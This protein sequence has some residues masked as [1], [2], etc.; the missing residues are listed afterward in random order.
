M[1]R[2]IIALLFIGLF[3]NVFCQNTFLIQPSLLDKSIYNYALKREIILIKHI[4]Y[5]KIIYEFEDDYSLDVFE[6]DRK[7]NNI[8]TM[9][10]GGTDTSFIYTDY[11]DTLV[12][13]EY[14]Y[15]FTYKDTI[16]ISQNTY[17]EKGQLE[18][19]GEYYLN[20]KNQLAQYSYYKYN[21][22]LLKETRVND[23]LHEVIINYKYDT[24]NRPQKIYYSEPRKISEVSYNYKND[25][26]IETSILRKNENIEKINILIFDVMQNLIKQ[27][28]EYVG[29]FKY[30]FHY[31]YK[32][33][34][35]YQI[36]NPDNKI[37]RIEYEF[38]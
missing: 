16:L 22:G 31:I 36:I 38:W 28:I 3:E 10:I 15:P 9:I 4:K 35:L 27:E 30:E 26:I 7:G 32:D 29:N 8:K 25:T 17:N 20:D 37:I 11:L 2:I 18:K 14:I 19:K 12:I 21:N 1:I 13:K 24:L 6:F 5:A 23:N 34:L 33:N